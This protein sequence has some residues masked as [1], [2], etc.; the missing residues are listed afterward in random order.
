MS[1]IK[2]IV[3]TGGPCGG[4]STVLRALQEE[5]G[6]RLVLVPEVATVLLDGGFPLPGR[7]L[8]WSEDWQAAFQ[9]A[10]LPLQISLE[11]SHALVAKKRQIKVLVCDRGLL[12]GAAYTPGGTTEFCKLYGVNETKAYQQYQ[13]II[14]LESLATSDPERYNKTGNSARFEPLERAQELERATK[15]VWQKH[16]RHIVVD[17]K[18]GIEGKIAETI[19]I[20][21]YL[22]AE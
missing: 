20:V 18:C 14:H 1:D 2:A 12:D 3:L 10:V 7:D 16:P 9:S 22:L 6:D 19:G 17:S 13:T 8:D 21:R 11:K 5:F 4:K 15:A